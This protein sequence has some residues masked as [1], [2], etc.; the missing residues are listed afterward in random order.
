MI[1]QFK[2]MTRPDEWNWITH[3]AKC[4]HMSDTQ[5]IVAYDEEGVIK[6]MAAFDS[7]TVDNCSIHI[8]IDNPFVIRRGFLHAICRHAFWTCGRDRMF[9]TIASNNEKSLKFVE[10]TGFYMVSMIGD[11][12]K[13]GVDL[14]IM[15]M[16]KDSCPWLVEY[17]EAA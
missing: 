2:S 17:E 12:L 13:K 16:D 7:F 3:R 4:K 9:A 11:G 6:A 5:G 8:A 1:I 10:H 14:I 15:R